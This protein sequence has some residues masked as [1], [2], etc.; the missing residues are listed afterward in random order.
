MSLSKHPGARGRPR[1]V[2][3]SCWLALSLVASCHAGTPFSTEDWGSDG[4][5]G[6]E[7]RGPESGGADLGGDRGDG[8]A[9]AP[10]GGDPSAGGETEGPRGGRT[11]GDAGGSGGAIAASDGGSEATATG[12]AAGENSGGSGA[13]GA[14]VPTAQ[15]VGRLST[16]P[17]ICWVYREGVLDQNAWLE[18]A[19]DYEAVIALWE[20]GTALVMNWLGICDPS[21]GAAQ[22]TLRILLDQRAS[23][24]ETI[25]GCDKPDRRGPWAVYPSEA[26]EYADCEWNMV[27]PRD[28]AGRSAVLHAFGHALGFAHVHESFEGAWDPV[29]ECPVLTTGPLTP[30]LAQYDATSVLHFGAPE[31]EIFL[32][33][34]WLDCD[35]QT[36]EEELTRRRVFDMLSGGDALSMA[37]IYPR[38]LQR[39]LGGTGW[40]FVDGYPTFREERTVRVMNEWS[41][42]GAHPDWFAKGQW[43]L[44]DPLE[45]LLI[46]HSSEISIEPDGTPWFQLFQSF[47]DPYGDGH[48]LTELIAFSTQ[49]HTAV[50]LS[51]LP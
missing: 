9:A 10:S 15:A 37:M 22:A 40:L 48:S 2:R 47:T 26:A 23:I 8:G 25:A 51:T 20:P 33:N 11:G 44:I 28:L 16:A 46:R 6:G 35:P 19:A 17:S 7:P 29:S 27:L 32:R 1:F 31:G 45:G 30:Y 13:G 4:G 5:S 41:A 12:G 38:S 50:L 34:P 14:V 36:A 42:R 18:R 24:G 39:R 49:K 21:G 3:L 43:T